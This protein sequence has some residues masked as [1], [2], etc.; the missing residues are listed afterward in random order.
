VRDRRFRDFT[1]NALTFAVREFIACLPVYRTYID[2]DTGE[3]SDM[4]RAV[5]E[6]T[7]AEVKRRNP[8]TDPTTF[9]FIRDQLLGSERLHTD[10]EGAEERLA[11]VARFQQV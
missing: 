5:L 7:T 2:P 10:S 8:R 1:L 11:F 3:M 4:D 9:D 6:S